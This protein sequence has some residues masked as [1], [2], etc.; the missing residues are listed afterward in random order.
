MTSTNKLLLIGVASFVG[1]S[2]LKRYSKP[3]IYYTNVQGNHYNAR[4]I[5]PF[6][7][8][9]DKNQ[10]GNKALLDHELIHWS[11][12]KRLGLMGYYLR[13][14]SEYYRYGYDNMPMEVE[15]RYMESAYCKTNYTS[16]VRS[17]CSK[18]VF[19]SRFR[20]F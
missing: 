8:F 7:I 17:G 9:I 16:C 2:F 11:Q 15:A 12:F 4:C 10:R 19:N 14:L 1:Y 3:S 6:G 5:P 20:S 13:Y 18:T